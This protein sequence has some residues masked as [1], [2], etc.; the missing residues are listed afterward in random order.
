MAKQSKQSAPTGP[1]QVDPE[2][3]SQS[4]AEIAQRSQNLISEFVAKQEKEPGIGDLQSATHIGKAFLEM[5][6]KMM[7]NPAKLAEAQASLWND[8]MKLWQSTASKWMGEEA[9]PVVE[10]SSGDRRF[11]DD[12]WS[13]NDVFDFIKHP[14]GNHRVLKID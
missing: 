1:T 13:E 11:K 6:A 10:P 9:E 7:E 2:K 5:T 8:Y 12:A 4:M 3:L 14:I